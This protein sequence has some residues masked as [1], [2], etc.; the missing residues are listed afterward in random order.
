MLS[1]VCD[2]N[3]PTHPP[4]DK[5]QAADQPN[6]QSQMEARL[7]GTIPIS[8]APSVL[9]QLI[10]VS[11]IFKFL[12]NIL[13]RKREPTSV[14]PWTLSGLETK[15]NLLLADLNSQLFLGCL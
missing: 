2:C 13:I 14:F 8:R 3:H 10:G 7:K 6:L 11:E 5:V 12:E 9:P 1:L 4:I 15:W